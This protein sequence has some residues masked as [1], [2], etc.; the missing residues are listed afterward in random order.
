MG[1]HQAQRQTEN[2]NQQGVARQLPSHKKSFGGRSEYTDT[3]GCFHYFITI[4]AKFS[5]HHPVT[6]ELRPSVDNR[7]S[8]FASFSLYSK[9][10]LELSTA[11][12]ILLKEFLF[13]HTLGCN[14][15]KVTMSVSWELF[16]LN[17][18]TQC[19]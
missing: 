11:L 16:L 19:A 9:N 7:D 14:Y 5:S 18:G 4:T 6:R 2:S 10:L 17:Y 8:F 12:C 15:T 3:F 1:A 13:Q